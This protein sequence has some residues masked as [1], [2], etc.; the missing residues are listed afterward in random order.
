MYNQF[1]S[2]K[3]WKCYFYISLISSPFSYGAIAKDIS[4]NATNTII[5]CNNNFYIT[6]S[7]KKADR[8]KETSIY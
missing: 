1:N 2:R 6:M 3:I 7:F 4:V 5:Y 8:G